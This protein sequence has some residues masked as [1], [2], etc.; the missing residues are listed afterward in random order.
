MSDVYLNRSVDLTTTN[1]TAVYTVP[2][3]DVTTTPPQKPVQAIINAIRVTNDSGGAVVIDALISD[4]ST[5]GDI[6]IAWQKSI[7][8]N[9]YEELL[10][11]P[12]VLENSDI[13]K[14]QAGGADALHVVVSILEIT[15]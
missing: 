11:R 15:P 7:A 1:L 3:A 14:V 4:A 8:S 2:T 13:L 5:A 6:K 9:T 12:I 10:T